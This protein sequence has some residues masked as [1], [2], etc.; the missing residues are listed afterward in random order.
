M[1]QERGLPHTGQTRHVGAELLVRPKREQ[2]LST[3]AFLSGGVKAVLQATVNGVTANMTPQT[4]YSSGIWSTSGGAFGLMS[5]LGPL[6]V[7]LHWEERDGTMGGKDCTKTPT[8]GAC[9]GDFTGVQQLYSG[10]LDSSGP[11]QTLS[12]SESGA[13]N[14]GAPYSIVAG[15]NHTLTV[16]V[17]LSG[18]LNG[19]HSR[20]YR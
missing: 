6:G 9:K 2:Q 20:L 12:V 14:T 11:V 13:S 7:D 17:G 19:L 1:Q 18:S 10:F 4:P 8:P 16:T 3:L 15:R 5:G